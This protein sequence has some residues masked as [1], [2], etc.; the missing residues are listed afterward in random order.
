MSLLMSWYHEYMMRIA[1][2]QLNRVS[3]EEPPPLSLTMTNIFEFSRTRLRGSHDQD[4]KRVAF[5]S[6]SGIDIGAQG[7]RPISH[8]TAPRSQDVERPSSSISSSTSSRSSRDPQGS[9]PKDDPRA[10]VF[11]GTSLLD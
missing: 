11:R 5:D 4:G 7:I 2:S 9:Q 1:K 6:S 3:F 8:F 10:P